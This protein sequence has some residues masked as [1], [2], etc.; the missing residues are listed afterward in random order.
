[1]ASFVYHGTFIDFFY[2]LHKQAP[3]RIFMIP[4]IKCALHAKLP[5]KLVNASNKPDENIARLS[6]LPATPVD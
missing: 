4:S 3:S 6:Y 5:F 2:G 1:M